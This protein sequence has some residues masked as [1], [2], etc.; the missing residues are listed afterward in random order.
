L[1]FR[2]RGR[3]GRFGERFGDELLWEGEEG[4]GRERNWGKEKVDFFVLR[5]N[6]VLRAVN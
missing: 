1:G 4:D 2:C 5:L 3:G 6:E